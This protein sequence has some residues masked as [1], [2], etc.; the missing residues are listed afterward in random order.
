MNQRTRTL[1]RKNQ[2]VQLAGLLLW[3]AGLILAGATAAFRVA[4][5]LLRFIDLP[6][7]IEIGV[8]LFIVGVGCVGLSLVMERIVDYRS[9]EDLRQL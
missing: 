4:R 2:G 3:R 1:N 5:F 8:A 6:T 7:Q 9:E